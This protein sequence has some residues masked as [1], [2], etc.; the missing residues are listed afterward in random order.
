MKKRTLDI[1][2]FNLNNKVFN[3][4][5]LNNKKLI[6]AIYPNVDDNDVIVCQKYK[7]RKIDLSIT[8]NQKT[9]YLSF[10]RNISF[11]VYKGDVKEIVSF[12]FS[13]GS[14]YNVIKALLNLIYKRDIKCIESIGGILRDSY[15][16]EVEVINKEFEDKEKMIKLLNYYLLRENRGLSVDYFLIGNEKNAIILDTNIIVESIL[17]DMN[18]TNNIKIGPFNLAVLSS[19]KDNECKCM[20]KISLSKYKKIIEK[21]L[22]Y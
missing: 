10:K 15:K 13:I 22:D 2:V 17:S 21:N 7:G 16:D 14:S 4:L 11:V 20:L 5:T 9:H 8:V 1:F 3:E 12:L 18:N 19:R 6:K